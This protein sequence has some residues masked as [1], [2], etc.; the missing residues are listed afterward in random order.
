[1]RGLRKAK[2]LGNHPRTEV[3]WMLELLLSILIVGTFLFMDGQCHGYPNTPTHILT[4]RVD[5]HAVQ[6]VLE[7]FVDVEGH[8]L[9]VPNGHRA[10][11]ATGHR[12]RSPVG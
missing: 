9:V 10:I 8:V 12:Q 7:L 4:K 5:G 6:I 3:N 11:R 1:M 2:L